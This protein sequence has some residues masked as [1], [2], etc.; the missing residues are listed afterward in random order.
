LASNPELETSESPVTEQERP[1]RAITMPMINAMIAAQGPQPL[2]PRV[3]QAIVRSPI[4]RKFL[5]VLLVLFLAKGVIFTFVFPP[6]SGHDEVAHYMYLEFVA[7]HG[8]PPVIPDKEDWQEQYAGTRN[9][10]AHDHMDP[11]LWQYCQFVT[12]D[13]Y[14]GCDDPKYM[15]T[16]VYA[17]TLADEVLPSGWV[18]T[19]NHPPLYYFLMTPVFWLFSAAGFV[20]KLYALR[21]AAIP[22]GLITVFFAY[23]TTK[24]IF[25]KDRFLALLVPA[26]V[27]FQPQISYE[28][29]M[30]NNDILSIAFTSI[31]FY[32]LALGLRRG[33]SWRI[34]V[35]TGFALGLAMLSKN[36]ATVSGL[37][38][39][40]AMILGIG[41]RNWK[42][43]IPRG[44]V[45]G[46]VAGLLIW[47]WYLYMWTTYGN[48][49]ALD[50]IESLQYW[51]YGGGPGRTVWD[52]LTDLQFAKDRWGETWGEFGWR[53]I[54]LGD[55]L[56][57]II[58][59]VC[60]VGLIGFGWWVVQSQ[61]VLRGQ[62]ISFRSE[63]GYFTFPSLVSLDDQS[64]S[65]RVD[66]VFRPDRVTRIAV[67]TLV[68][69]CLVAYFAI[70]QFGTTF[71]LTQARYYFPSVNA[72]AILVML[73]YRALIPK[74]L[75]SW[76]EAIFLL[77]FFVVNLL[78]FAE[79]VIPYWTRN[80]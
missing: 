45:T 48:L 3:R 69:A 29:A 37:I 51:N 6:F 26:F 18:Y 14:R 73:G 32:L 47:P 59:G 77:A 70:L 25:P 44:A 39:A 34:C 80:L 78:V 43:W 64:R 41:I 2:W 71:S 12:N 19:A 7:E 42:E 66:D 56:L 72:F 35:L 58:L 38:I 13:W 11:R 33:F 16:P 4:E 60:V 28:A 20:V 23:R 62:T 15:N 22:F 17:I 55:G 68:I 31:V 36:T 75:H 24:V 46:I 21:L 79:Y 57:R 54:P 27:A 1:A 30:L 63:H 74:R 10:T 67:L 9:Q 76:A 65:D 40:V 8:R 50:R 53:L 49:T 52:Q 5:W 61:L